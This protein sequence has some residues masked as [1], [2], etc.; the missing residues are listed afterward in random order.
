MNGN[1]CRYLTITT[2]AFSNNDNGGTQLGKIVVTD[3]F[4]LSTPSASYTNTGTVASAI[5]NLIT[6]GDFV[7]NSATLN[8]FT[9]NNLA[10]TIAGDFTSYANIDIAGDL[11]IQVSGE[12]SLDVSNT[13]AVIKARNLFFSAY[14]LWNQAD[15]TITENATFDIVDYFRNGFDLGGR[16]T[17]GGDII[18]VSF[19]ATA[20]KGFIQRYSSTSA[21]NFNV[22]V[23]GGSFRNLNDSMIDANSFNVIAGTYF[24]NESVARINVDN[25]NVTTGT[26]FANNS[27]SVIRAVSFNVTSER[28]F[29]NDTATINVDN[30]F[31]VTSG[32]IFSN[33]DGAIINADSFNVTAV[34]D[35]TNTNSSTINAD[36]VTIEVI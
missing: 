3:I 12:A 32:N 4:S 14:D 21:D 26:Y 11:S 27:D 35:F 22:T 31:N 1:N 36:N 29:V 25:F 19:N 30:F 7:Y 17:G 2:D 33:I 23:I 34:D 24:A 5:L 16:G 10:F 28:D 6:S 18:A 13:G 8:R 9:F 20:G 15:I